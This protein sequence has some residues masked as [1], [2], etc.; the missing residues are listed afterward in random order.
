MKKNLVLTG[1]MGVGKSTLGKSLS[2]SLNMKFVDMDAIL[3]SKENM[4]IK[5]IFETKGEKHFRKIEEEISLE[6]LNKLTSVVALGGGAFI[7]PVIRSFILKNCISFW[8][9]LNLKSLLDRVADSPRRPL[10]TDK[11]LEKTLSELYANRKE[12][13]ALANHKIDC[14]ESSKSLIV[15]KIIKIYENETN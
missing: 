1:M 8:L 13:Y 15:N 5:K 2:T 4:S 7:N 10:L 11:N 3:E 12:V 6:Y 9:D 14:N